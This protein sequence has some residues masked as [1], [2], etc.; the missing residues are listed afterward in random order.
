[1]CGN[2]WGNNCCIWI[3]L[4]LIAFC[5]CGNGCGNNCGNVGGVGCGNNGCGC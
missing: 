5:C 2:G 1:M 3:I 4:I